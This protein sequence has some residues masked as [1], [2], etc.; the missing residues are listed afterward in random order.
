[1]RGAGRLRGED[2][3][4]RSR[5]RARR[6]MRS[7]STTSPPA[8]PATVRL[9]YDRSRDRARAVDRPGRIAAARLQP[10]VGNAAAAAA[11]HRA[12]GRD[13]ARRRRASTSRRRSRAGALILFLV[14]Y[15]GLFASV[16][17]GMAVA[18]DAT[19]GER[20]RGSLEPLL[21]TP[22]STR[23]ARRR[24]VAGDRRLRRAG[25]AADAGRVLP[26]AELRAA[27][28]GRHSVP[29]RQRRA[30]PL[31]GRFCCRWCCCCRPC[32]CTSGLRGRTLQGSAEQR[33]G[34]ALRR[35]ASSRSC[36]SSCR[37]RSRRGCC[38][39]RS[40]ASTRC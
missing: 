11:R 33:L 2:P 27:A 30:R 17:G 14:A 37:K 38:G 35:V 23:R 8:R 21:T 25:R 16:M 4:R 26:D 1:M 9:V 15:Y 31:C 29:V 28:G 7:S 20:E 24:Q 3:R 36:S 12:A 34:A 6:S 5:R 13:P 19:A 18:L 39:C 22:L 32:C 40:P 10:A